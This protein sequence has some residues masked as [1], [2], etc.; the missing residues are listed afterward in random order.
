[1]SYSV[2][3]CEMTLNCK[4]CQRMLYFKGYNFVVILILNVGVQILIYCVQIS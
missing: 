2:Q 4:I 1:M 3:I